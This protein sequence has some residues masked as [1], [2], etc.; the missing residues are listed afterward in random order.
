MPTYEYQC[1]ECNK[2][3]EHIHSMSE[4]PVIKCIKCDKI[5]EKIISRNT[6]G[7]IMKGGSEAINWKE[8]RIRTKRSESMAMKQ[9]G[10]NTGKRVTPNIAGVETGSWSDAQKMAKEAG[11]N[12]ES[13]TPWVEKE[14]KEKKIIV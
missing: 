2:I 7:F 12:H 14:K 3:E 5:M 4:S 9:K 13:Y 11:L 6:T 10:M 1:S 8:K